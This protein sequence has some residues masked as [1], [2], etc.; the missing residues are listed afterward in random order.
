MEIAQQRWHIS[1][2]ATDRPPIVNQ[3]FGLQRLAVA[4]ICQFDVHSVW[5]QRQTPVR[6]KFGAKTVKHGSETR[7][8]L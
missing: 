3:I 7:V 8:R 6:V 5:V 2:L 4:Y 1:H